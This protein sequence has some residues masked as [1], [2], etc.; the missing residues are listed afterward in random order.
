MVFFQ[1]EAL[2]VFMLLQ[3]SLFALPG[4]H[5]NV[6]VSGPWSAGGLSCSSLNAPL[7]ASGLSKV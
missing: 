1:N 7:P 4:A 5:R 3:R 6:A 2:Q